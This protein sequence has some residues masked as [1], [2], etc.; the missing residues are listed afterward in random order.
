MP[1][2]TAIKIT[3]LEVDNDIH[4]ERGDPARDS[5]PVTLKLEVDLEIV[6]VRGAKCLPQT[7]DI[8]RRIADLLEEQA[9][10]TFDGDTVH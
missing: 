9:R 8:L 1:K 5:M 10:G 2:N 3:K 7:H 6:G 4:F